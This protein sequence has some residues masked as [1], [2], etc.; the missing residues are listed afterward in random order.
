M[1]SK[2]P[3][4]FISDRTG[5][6]AETMG[7]S[8]LSQFNSIQFSRTTLPFVDNE[9]KALNAVQRIEQSRIKTG[10][11]PIVFSTMVNPHL[12]D[13]IGKSDAFV[14]DFFDAFI[15][16]LESELGTPSTQALGRSHGI[17]GARNYDTRI[18]AV[19]FTL[20]HDDGLGKGYEQADIIL[21]GVSRSGKTPTCLYLALHYGIRAANYP[22]TPDDL[23]EET[24]PASLKAW[25]GKLHGLTISPERL[26]LIRKERMPD[27][28]YAS[29]SQCRLEVREAEVIFRNAQIPYLDAGTMSVEEIASTIL[30]QR[31]LMHHD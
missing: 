26:H 13:I 9:E 6:T 7:H 8:L 27:S 24:L 20:D 15:S 22:L 16:P 17:E 23:Q 4:F 1:S 25:S 29:L 5:I 30:H 21:V 3:V 31:N 10:N 11:R 28:K 19:N 12:R 2:R 14:V 18:D